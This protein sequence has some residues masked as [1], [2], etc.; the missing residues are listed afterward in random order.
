M[1]IEQE[2]DLIFQWIHDNSSYE[3]IAH[4]LNS[5]LPSNFFW[6]LDRHNIRVTHHLIIGGDMHITNDKLE[7]FLDF[8]ASSLINNNL[9]VSESAYGQS[10]K[11][12]MDLDYRKMI[13]P[14][15][16]D[17]VLEHIQS[18]I[19]YVSE[20]K[21]LNGFDP[22]ENATFLY[23]DPK[24]DK[25]GSLYKCGCHLIFQN[26][27]TDLNLAN[28]VVD[29]VIDMMNKKFP[30]YSWNDIIEK[31]LEHLR[32]PY[33]IKVK[34]NG[35]YRF[36]NMIDQDGN[37]KDETDMHKIIK[38]SSILIK[39]PELKRLKGKMIRD[40]RLD[41]KLSKEAIDEIKAVLSK[42]IDVK[43]IIRVDEVTDS[44][45]L[46]KLEVTISTQSN[47]KEHDQKFHIL[48]GG[49]VRIKGEKGYI[50]KVEKE[51]IEKIYKELDPIHPT[52]KEVFKN[53]L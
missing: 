43:D 47:N 24:L 32:M 9:G 50:L 40:T 26:F 16:I 5:L 11:F 37:I 14:I 45:K 4:R 21:S 19:H 36:V 17:T 48:M 53:I 20:F 42:C 7:E 49:R 44:R 35:I 10:S 30:E 33:S 34:D 8:Y 18:I 51:Q 38:L 1:D 22:T 15:Q 12:F 39:T 29:Y 28:R 46:V 31:G 3:S 23:N 52:A 41:I 6:K 27:I 25:H 13:E 2:K